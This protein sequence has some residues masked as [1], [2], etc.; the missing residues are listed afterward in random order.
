MPKARKAV[1]ASGRAVLQ[2][3]LPGV[4]LSRLGSGVVESSWKKPFDN[5][6]QAGLLLASYAFNFAVIQANAPSLRE[7]GERNA[8]AEGHDPEQARQRGL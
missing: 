2:T 4:A 6:H 5:C 7:A 8:A 1:P 3:N